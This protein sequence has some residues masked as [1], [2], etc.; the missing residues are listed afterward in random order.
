VNVCATNAPRMSD[1][2]ATN[3]HPPADN[4]PLESRAPGGRAR[5]YA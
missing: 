1:D 2:A 5:T 4:M 3:A